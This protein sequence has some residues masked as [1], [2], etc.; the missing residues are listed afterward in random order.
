MA[1]RLALDVNRYVDFC[2]GVVETVELVR[3]ANPV[4]LPF[5]TVSELRSGFRLGNQAERNETALGR[6]LRRERV[7]IEFPTEVTTHVY[8]SLFAQL[9]AIG[10]P[11]PSNDI[12]IAAIVLEHDLT[13]HSRDKHFDYLPQ[14]SRI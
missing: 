5:I 7:R 10:K 4:V 12:W 8:A 2:N 9:R 6:F 1:I 3:R 13:L 11:I 14:L